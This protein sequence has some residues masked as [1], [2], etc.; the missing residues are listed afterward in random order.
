M[1]DTDAALTALYDACVAAGPTLCALHANTT[2]LV[3][4]RVDA[5]LAA[6]HVAPAAV[7]TPATPTAPADFG[8]VDYSAAV[9]LLLQALEFPYSTGPGI[10]QALAALERGNATAVYADSDAGAIASLRLEVCPGPAP[11][12]PY[13]AGVLDI[14]VPITCGDGPADMDRSLGAARRAYEEMLS[15]SSFANAWYGVVE[16]PCS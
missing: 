3:R 6:V 11:G 7:Y 8:A 9:G 5:L 15:L 16:E 2:A 1:L 10:A 4:A 13:Q 14:S 12:E